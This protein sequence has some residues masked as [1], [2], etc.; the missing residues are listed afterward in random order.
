MI[1]LLTLYGLYSMCYVIEKRVR[2]YV[3]VS[4]LFLKLISLQ[5]I[6]SK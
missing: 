6:D 3:A 2:L 4:M 5:Y 1:D